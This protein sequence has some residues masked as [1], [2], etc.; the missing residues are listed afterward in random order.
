MSYKDRV[1]NEEV[2]KNVGENRC[3]LDNIRQGREIGSDMF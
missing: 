3:L 2:M 1:S